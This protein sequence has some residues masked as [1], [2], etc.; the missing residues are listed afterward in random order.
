MSCFV[1][2]H[3]LITPDIPLTAPFYHYASIFGPCPRQCSF[4]LVL[5]LPSFTISLLLCPLPLSQLSVSLILLRILLLHLSSL[6]L[7]LLHASY[8]FTHHFS[9]LTIHSSFFFTAQI[10]H[11][12]IFIHCSLLI[13]YALS[14]IHCSFFTVHSSSYNGNCHYHSLPCA[15]CFRLPFRPMPQCQSCPSSLYVFSRAVSN[16]PHHHQATLM[17]ESAIV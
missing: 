3:L 10:H 4:F 6:F 1:T 16:K 13:R 5:P 2:L 12:L 17:P 9:F 11:S 14:I 8:S 15:S 7:F